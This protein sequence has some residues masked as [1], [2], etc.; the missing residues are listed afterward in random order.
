MRKE[1]ATLLA[2]SG[3]GWAITGIVLV[4]HTVEAY[5]QTGLNFPVVLMGAL[6]SV[7]LAL[8]ILVYRALKCL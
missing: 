3:L 7:Q 4:I 8:P 2:V 5:V 1:M 6:A